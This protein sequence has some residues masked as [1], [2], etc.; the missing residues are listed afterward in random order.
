MVD[1]VK[2]IMEIIER[3][4]H[5]AMWILVGLLFY[6]VVIV[7][8]YFGVARLLILKVHDYLTRPRQPVKDIIEHKI[9]RF[10]ITS[11]STYGYF[12]A[13]IHRLRNR[14]T[15]IDTDYIHSRDVKWL[16]DAI[17]EKIERDKKEDVK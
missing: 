16:A 9:D 15:S 11:D 2:E 6:K 1:A 13:Q 5:L 4:P 3:L 8:S 7:G 12:I 14:V 10:F 17:T